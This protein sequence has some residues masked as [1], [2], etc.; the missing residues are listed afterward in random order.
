MSHVAVVIFALLVDSVVGDPEWLPHPVIF[1][2]RWVSFW[3]HHWNPPPY[4]E[5]PLGRVFLG[6]ILAVST[7]GLSWLLPFLLLLWFN[8]LLPGGAFLLNI[9]LMS[10]TIA[11]KGLVD[12]GRK[13][14]LALTKQGLLAA[15]AEV[16]KI[17]GRDTDHLSDA[18][19]VRATV[20]TLAENIVDA[21][22]SPVF[23]GLIGGAPLAMAYRAANTLDS[24]VGYK[25]ER[26]LLFGRVSARQDDLLNYIPARLTAL[27]LS[28]AIGL[29][30]LSL[31]QAWVALRHDARRHPS[32]NSGI[33]ESMV[34]GALSVQLGGANVYDGVV[35]QRATMGQARRWLVANDILLAIRLVNLVSLSMLVVLSLTAGGWVLWRVGFRL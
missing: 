33:P 31:R 14:H 13:V 20:E 4:H 27:L 28:V 15:R 9:L 18:E 1:I 8:H 23:F 25:S 29:A 17:V 35:S 10:T 21:I 5:H 3:E 6:F 22:V 7:V 26:Y 2:G 19:V 30:Q 24:M 12:A 16:S 32:P 34:A 11:W